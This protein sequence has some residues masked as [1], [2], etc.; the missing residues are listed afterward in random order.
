MKVE[1]IEDDRFKIFHSYLYSF[2]LEK[3]YIL[4]NLELFAFLYCHYY[5]HVVLDQKR[6]EK[7]KSMKKH[8]SSYTEAANLVLKLSQKTLAQTLNRYRNNKK[9]TE[10][11]KTVEEFI[12]I[13]QKPQAPIT[14][15]HLKT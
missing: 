13:P 6:I 1:D 3:L 5:R 14:P 12:N 9:F 7:K 15:G 11:V 4:V 8:A 2:S 10:Y